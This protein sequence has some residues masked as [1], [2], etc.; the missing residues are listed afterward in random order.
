MVVVPMATPVTT[1]V[2]LLTVATD[3][4]E[5]D[6]VPPEVD[7]ERVVVVPTQVTAVPEMAAGS[8]FTVSIAVRVQPVPMVYVII[9]LPEDTAVAIPDE[10]PMVA[11]DVVPLAQVPPAG[12]LVNVV[13]LPSH[14]DKDPDNVDGNG[15]TV[16]VVVVRQPV[17]SVYVTTATP[18][19]LPVTMP[20]VEPTETIVP[21]TPQVPPDEA[22]ERVVVPP[23]HIA[24]LPPV[25]AAGTGLTVTTVDCEHPIGPIA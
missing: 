20:D 18:D 15:F 24:V 4:F 9:E 3:V 10:E 12:V 16:I 1:P 2:E 19:E 6:H 7:E 14:I 23:T 5:L 8:G 25:M 21:V 22:E 13:E 17:G 11:T